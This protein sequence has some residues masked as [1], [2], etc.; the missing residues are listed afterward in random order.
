MWS[1][2]WLY[3]RNLHSST[4]RI[5][6]RGNLLP[7]THLCLRVAEYILGIKPAK[8]GEIRIHGCEFVRTMRTVA[9]YGEG[10]AHGLQTGAHVAGGDGRRV[11]RAHH[12]RAYRLVHGAL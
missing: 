11:H 7:S 2:A 3:P 12:Q 6:V 4:R 9:N 10:F 1:C 5:D 8:V